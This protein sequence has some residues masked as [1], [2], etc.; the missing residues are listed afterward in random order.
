M[1]ASARGYNTD[2]QLGALMDDRIVAG[3]AETIQALRAELTQAVEAGKDQKILFELGEVQIDFQ[4][5]VTRDASGEGGI[6]FGVVSFGAKGRLEDQ[7]THRIVLNM[8]PIIID[9]KGTRRPASVNGYV[10]REPVRDTRH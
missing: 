6:N 10:P 1:S 3:V 2:A 8:Q 9:E 5:A 7:H 4:I